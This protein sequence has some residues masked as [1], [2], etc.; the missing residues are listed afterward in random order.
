MAT[1][2]NYDS[3]A[4]Y[5]SQLVVEQTPPTPA[6]MRE[7]YRMLNAYYLGNGLYD[8][9]NQQLKSTKTQYHPLK[10]V[11]NPAWR[12]VEFYAS[13]LYP[14]ALPDALPM[15]SDNPDVLEAVQKVWGWSNFSSVKQK[16][17]RW[18]AIY[19]DWYI[20][21]Q[22]KGDPVDSVFMSL[23]KPEYVTSQEMDE[24]GF[25]TYIRMD[26]P[27][28]DEEDSENQQSTR[29][30]T[31]EW[32]KET[33][34]VRVWIHSQGLD[35][36]IEE[37]GDPDITMTFEESHGEDFIPIVYQPF[38]DDGAGRGSGAYSAQLDKIDEA[39]RQAT[40]LAQILFRYNRAIWA[41]TSTGSDASGRPMPPIS[42]SGI[43]ESDGTVKIGDD[44]VLALPSQADLKPLV[45]PLNYGD[46]LE[47][48]NAQL[49]EL[50]K[51]LPELAYY[52]LR[53]LRDVSGRAVLFLMD[54]MISRIQ[55]ARGN[56]ESALIRAH[57]MALTVGSNFG[58][59]EGLGAFEEDAFA[60]SF[61]ERTVL[62][63]DKQSLAVLVQT[64]T[65]AGATLFAAGKAAGMTEQEAT[66][67]AETGLFEEEIGGR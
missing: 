29:T 33:Q 65:L 7:Y 1:L 6:F 60:H 9:L 52:E 36:K 28:W 57:S 25:L 18:F 44:D 32:D 2:A 41:A 23:I 63:E 40:R 46:A 42:M 22:T 16:W 30:H 66:D 59:F 34:L 15:E 24:R 37:L 55:E 47:I 20:K 21:I 67:L 8:Y 27:L 38:R 61:L 43:L 49:A 45:P 5:Y 4:A 51:D 62:P 14:G 19:G 39:N 12:V 54:D 56:A 17:A 26:V 10:P 13:K 11:R 50:S 31:E 48:L 58:I 53:N 64:F 35:I 3:Y